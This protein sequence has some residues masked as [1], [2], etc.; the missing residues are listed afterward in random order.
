VWVD[1]REALTFRDE[2]YKKGVIGLAGYG[3]YF[4]RD[5]VIRGEK[6]AAVNWP[7]PPTI[8][9]HSFTVGLSSEEMPSACIAPSGDVLLAAGSVMVRSGDRGRTWSEPESLP[10]KLGRV[11]DYGNAMFATTDGRP[12]VMLYTSEPDEPGAPP[13][14]AIAESSD[15][16]RTWSDPVSSTI[17]P[18]WPTIPPALTPYGPVV[19]VGENELL[20]F[21]LGGVKE[22][23]TIFTDV[24][25]FGATRAKAYVIRSKDAGKSWS[26]PIELDRPRWTD[27]ERG[28][29]PGSLDF[30]EPSTVVMGDTVMTLIRPIYS[31]YMWQCWSYDR[32]ATWDAAGRATFPGYAQSMTR[33]TSGTVLC[34]H[35]YPLYSVNVSR[36]GGLN[37]DAGTV[38]DYPVWGM[39]TMHEVEPDVV[40]CTYMNAERSLPLLAQLIRVTP[41]RIEPAT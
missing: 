29:I 12:A 38:I 11:T 27:A 34:A 25:T 10:E 36:D 22:E 16:G 23:G 32:G 18:D 37:W 30:T 9:V 8:P 35:R 26:S 40:L 13:R 15:D 33:T 14:I 39:G 24:R 7:E 2:T 4:F 20:R 17:A 28:T 3:W 21:L 31:P 1:G 41:E 19:K 5:A 6:S